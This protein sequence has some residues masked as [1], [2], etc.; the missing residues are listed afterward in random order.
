MLPDGVGHLRGGVVNALC[1]SLAAG[2]IKQYNG[3]LARFER[4]CSSFGLPSWQRATTGRVL[5][6]LV[7]VA[8]GL[9]RPGP[10]LN[11]AI[12]ALKIAFE[13]CA[14]VA[15]PLTS[16]LVERVRRGLVSSLTTRP[17]KPTQPLP[18]AEVR[19]WLESLP[20]TDA[21]PYERLRMKCAVLAAL[22]L[23]ARPSDLCCID[24]RQLVFQP[25]LSGVEVSLLK[26]K[27]DYHRDGAV[28]PVQACSD[29]RLC[30]V[31]ACHRLV[32]LNRARFPNAAALFIDY[33]SG[34]PLHANQ[35][36]AILKEAC[37]LAGLAPFFT[38]RNF[39]P[40]GATRGIEGHLP[41]DL[42]MH[43]GRWRNHDTVYNHYLRSART[44]NSSDVL[45]GLDLGARSGSP[46]PSA[47]G[48][49]L[50]AT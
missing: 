13:T 45:V 17:R 34:A 24:A 6:F 36:G 42:V 32:S 25:D 4:A 18:V 48:P 37:K 30:F 43:I 9:S 27:N 12:A 2:T 46:V 41:L 47:V 3:Y 20:A 44:I 39:R 28:L 35:I 16:Q 49:S 23:I 21:L 1:Q 50:D 29:P 22:V 8:N 38:A 14:G 11:S 7:G 19:R 26:F 15:S 33:R 10:S 40:G 5:A 31:L